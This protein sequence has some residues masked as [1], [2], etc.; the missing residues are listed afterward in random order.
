M[1]EEINPV[2]VFYPPEFLEHYPTF[3]IVFFKVMRNIVVWNFIKF[4]IFCLFDKFKLICNT[5]HFKSIA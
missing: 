3:S 5:F 2:L 1:F 4:L